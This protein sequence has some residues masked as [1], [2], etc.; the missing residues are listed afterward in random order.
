MKNVSA[1]LLKVVGAIT[2]KV[3]KGGYN[4]FQK[5]RY[6]TEGDLIDAV[7]DE[8]VKNGLMITTSVVSSAT[9]QQ[10]GSDQYMT[11]VILKHTV[12]DTDSGEALE[13]QSAGSG[14]DKLDKGV[15]KAITGAN[16]YFLLKTFLL[17]G[18][19][20]P[21]NDGQQNKPAQ[22][23][24]SKPAQQPAQQAAKPAGQGFLAKKAEQAAPATK[25]AEVKPA[26]KPAFGVGKKKEPVQQTAP[27][28]DEIPDAPVETP[29]EEDAQ[30]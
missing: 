21:E 30:F 1:K 16:K 5:Y 22:A 19:D 25:P 15:Y 10:A 3:D 27:D 8:L 17:S 24:Q 7:R 18:D 20:D 11:H 28:E 13:I 26:S 14:A 12:I 2:G 4:S 23:Q 9:S 29:E 6:V